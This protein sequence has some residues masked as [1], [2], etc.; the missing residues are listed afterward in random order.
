MKTKSVYES[1]L[2]NSPP[3]I[4]HFSC[5][6][7]VLLALLLV[8]LPSSPAYASDGQC[9]DVSIGWYYYGSTGIAYELSV[10]PS[11]CTIYVT[12]KLDTGYPVDPSW[13]YTN[14]GQGNPISPTFVLTGDI[15]IPY[16]HTMYI[17]AKAW[18]PG[19]TESVNVASDDQH[20]PND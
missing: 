12:T 9:G 15:L 5:L 20:N 6:I 4:G 3:L 11:S 14:P 16:G 8:A 18:Q 10:S 19:W 2:V 17:K 7:G 13:H 1:A